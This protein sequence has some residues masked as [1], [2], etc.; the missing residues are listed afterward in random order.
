MNFIFDPSLVFYLPL[1]EL[2]GNSFMSGDA[3][4]HTCTVTGALWRL[5][6]REFDGVDDKI[7]CGQDASLELEQF[8]LEAWVKPGTDVSDFRAILTKE[9]GYS[10]RNF[11]LAI[12]QTTGYLCFR[13]TVSGVSKACD[14]TKA[15]NDE[16]WHHV[17]ATYDKNYMRLYLDASEIE[18]QAETGTPDTSTS[19]LYIGYE[20]PTDPRV[21]LNLIGEVRIYR[22][23][24]TP[25]EIQRNYL[26][27]KWRYQ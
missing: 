12:Y 9:T 11:W 19:N 3:C 15:I 17:L 23:A 25:Q 26:G 7:D 6:G 13:L 24:L 5:G 2:D 21:F 22:R 10:D 27:T 8:T 16:N 14:S 4:G 20:M 18:R 1:C